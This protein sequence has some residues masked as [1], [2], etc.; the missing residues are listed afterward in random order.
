MSLGIKTA[1][2]IQRIHSVHVTT[3]VPADIEIKGIMNSNWWWHDNAAQDYLVRAEDKDDTATAR[4]ALIAGTM[5]RVPRG[6]AAEISCDKSSLQMSGYHLNP[7]GS[8]HSTAFPDGWQT[9][10]MVID[11]RTG[12][13]DYYISPHIRK[14][15]NTDFSLAELPTKIMVHYTR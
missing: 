11:N 12:T 7:D 10:P 2:G 8:G 1:Q 15:D 6:C 4:A 5:I 14:S 13:E 9:Q 3:E